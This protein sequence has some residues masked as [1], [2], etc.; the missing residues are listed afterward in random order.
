MALRMIAS[1]LPLGS[2]M[3]GLASERIAE[4]ADLH[5]SC[6]RFSYSLDFGWNKGGVINRRFK[7]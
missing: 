4:F 2:R 3:A 5:V 7:N 1:N 6:D